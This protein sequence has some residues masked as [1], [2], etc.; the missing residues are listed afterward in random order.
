[1]AEWSKAQDL[2][3]CH[4]KWRGFKP[5][6]GHFCARPSPIQSIRSRFQYTSEQVRLKVRPFEHDLSTPTRVN[7]FDSHT[8]NTERLTGSADSTL[9]MNARCRSPHP[10]TRCLP[11]HAVHGRRRSTVRGHLSVH[12]SVRLH[13]QCG[14]EPTGRT[15][16]L[17]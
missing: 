9:H 14:S 5:R 15:C 3:S 11:V 10:D 17:Y 12:L 6:P 13:E 16:T 8:V 2:G 1:M 4:V 7:T